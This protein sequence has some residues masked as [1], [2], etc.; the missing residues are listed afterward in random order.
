MT[1]TPD[2]SAA[3]AATHVSVESMLGEAFRLGR[4]A[5]WTQGPLDWIVTL[6]G[7]LGHLPDLDRRQE[8]ETMLDAATDM[9]V[10]RRS[11][12]AWRQRF[13]DWW[14][15]TRI[16]AASTLLD[17]AAIR[18]VEHADA[19][20]LRLAVDDAVGYA[21]TLPADDPMRVRFEE[22]LAG[23]GAEINAPLVDAPRRRAA[24]VRTTAPT[25]GP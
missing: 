8:I 18:F 14:N 6:T 24:T 3:E 7:R 4:L 17:E 19:E 21:E 2:L 13:S 10:L 22:T 9:V 23:L 16:E 15:G 20:G 25:S 12:W 11:S 1:V 5:A